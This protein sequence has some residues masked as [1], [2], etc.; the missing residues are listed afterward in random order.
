MYELR[1]GT[2]I[3]NVKDRAEIQSFLDAKE[4]TTATKVR[5]RGETTWSTV[6]E[7]LFYWEVGSEPNKYGSPLGKRPELKKRWFGLEPRVTFFCPNCELHLVSPFSEV[8]TDDQCQSCGAKFTVPGEHL[9][10]EWIAQTSVA[11]THSVAPTGSYS[12]DSNTSNAN[13]SKVVLILLLDMC[14]YALWIYLFKKCSAHHLGFTTRTLNENATPLMAF[15]FYLLLA[16]LLTDIWQF[17]E[18]RF[19][20]RLRNSGGLK[21]AIVLLIATVAVSSGRRNETGHLDAIKAT[22]ALTYL[23]LVFAPL[24]WLCY[25]SVI[26]K[27]VPSQATVSGQ[28]EDGCLGMLLYIPSLC[29]FL[30]VAFVVDT[31]GYYPPDIPSPTNGSSVARTDSENETSFVMRLTGDDWH[32]MSEERK[33]FVCHSVSSRLQRKHPIATSA[34]LYRELNAY[35]KGNFGSSDNVLEITAMLIVA[36]ENQ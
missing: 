32:E 30:F 1:I 8:E 34:W 12:N 25:D 28:S 23:Y 31:S 17:R 6:G 24:W 10:R 11:K 16:W 13:E 7:V 20:R 19:V 36:A 22:L 15:A 14:G 2:T 5:L 18:A 27:S 4:I 26:S 3:R 9:K 29:V 35:F 21:N 33:R